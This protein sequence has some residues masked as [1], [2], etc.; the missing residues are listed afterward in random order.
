MEFINK[1]TIRISK[2]INELDRFVLDFVKI[3]EKHTKYVIVSG[4]VSILF[5]RARA[6]ED[7]DIFIKDLN[8]DKFK[9]LY[10]DLMH[11]NYWCLNTSNVNEAYKYLLDGLAIRFGKEKK[12]VPNFKVK[13]VKNR[14]DRETLN[15]PLT[16][17]M[18]VGKIR[19]SPIERQ[20]AFKRY[21]L[22]SDK[23]VEDARHLEILFKGKIDNKKIEKYKRLIESIK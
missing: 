5:G 17:G 3:L 2:V 20:I 22:K 11:N 8:R 12:A 13:F 9:K 18:P 23:D 6:T 21:Y 15:D 14:I 19:I 7:V 1:K 16:V 4:Y 10:S